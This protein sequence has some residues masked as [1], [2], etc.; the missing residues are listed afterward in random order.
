MQLE[1]AK[2]ELA[3]RQVRLVAISAD[4]AEDSRALAERLGVSMPLL[5][6]PGVAVAERYGVAMVGQDIAVPSMLIVMPDRRIAWR[7]VG[8]GASDRPPVKLLLEQLDRVE[9]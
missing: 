3:T 6:D 4:T 8:E 1:Q 2:D 9:Q 7:Y 5:A